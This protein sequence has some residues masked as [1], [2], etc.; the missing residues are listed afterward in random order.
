MVWANLFQRF[1]EECALL[2]TTRKDFWFWLVGQ[3]AGFQ[4]RVTKHPGLPMKDPFTQE[5]HEIMVIYFRQLFFFKLRH[6]HISEIEAK[7]CW[8]NRSNVHS[9]VMYDAY[10]TPK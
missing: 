2:S 4:L 1:K 8:G 6:G 3:S 5:V 7:F 9:V 10:F